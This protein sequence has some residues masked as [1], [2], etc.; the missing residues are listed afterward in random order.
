MMTGH[1]IDALLGR[2][3]RANLHGPAGGGGVRSRQLQ[4]GAGYQ[5]P[6]VGLPRRARGML[7]CRTPRLHRRHLCKTEAAPRDVWTCLHSACPLRRHAAGSS[8]NRGHAET[9]GEPSDRGALMAGPQGKSDRVDLWEF[10]PDA[11][12]GSAHIVFVDR[13]FN[14]QV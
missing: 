7:P 12:L 10:A 5:L 2:V 3:C 14:D 1:E 4:R 8:L 11:S 6:V 13:N 9:R